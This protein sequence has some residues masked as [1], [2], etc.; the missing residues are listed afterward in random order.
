MLH[1]LLT[2]LFQVHV[3]KAMLMLQKVQLNYT[4]GKPIMEDWLSSAQYHQLV[5]LHHPTKK[6]KGKKVEP[7]Q[8]SK[9]QSES[10]LLHSPPFWAIPYSRLFYIYFLIF[11][12]YLTRSIC[13]VGEVFFSPQPIIQLGVSLFG[14]FVSFSI[15]TLLSV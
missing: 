8:D 4:F 6:K 2:L 7:Q 10:F 3:G 5:F 15:L 11:L 12:G 14:F 13:R 9:I 1:L